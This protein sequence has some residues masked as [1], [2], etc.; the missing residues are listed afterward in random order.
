MLESTLDQFFRAPV[1]HGDRIF[2]DFRAVGVNTKIVGMAGSI[3]AASD[4]HEA[5]KNDECG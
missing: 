4:L 2:S 3:E 1:V 5:D